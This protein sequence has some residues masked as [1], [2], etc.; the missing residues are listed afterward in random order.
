MADAPS[1]VS[2]ELLAD[3]APLSAKQR[4]FVLEYLGSARFNATEAYVRAYGAERKVAESL[5]S[6]L[7]GTAK[8]RAVIDKHQR[9]EEEAAV[10][11]VE[12]LDRELEA[13]I[14]F[15]IRKLYRPA[16][17]GGAPALDDEG[18]QL[19]EPIPLPELPDDVA[20]AIAGV[21]VEELFAGASGERFEIG[22]IRKWKRF[23]RVAAMA[24]AYKRRGALV[25]RS[26]V[27]LKGKGLVRSVTINIGT[28]KKPAKGQG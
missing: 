22:R 9:A 13:T 12:D 26:E 1:P 4:R 23:D 8:V 15:D 10:L 11:R 28:G 6:R 24:L 14:N 7:M 19:Y 18:R 3:L 2:A 5:A 21:D 20:R 17:K 16:M 25:E 27:K